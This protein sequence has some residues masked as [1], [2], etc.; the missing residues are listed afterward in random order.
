MV[1]VRTSFPISRSTSHHEQ[2]SPIHSDISESSSLLRDGDDNGK[3]NKRIMETPGVTKDESTISIAYPTD[4]NSEGSESAS[5]YITVIST[6]EEFEQIK[7]YLSS[8]HTEQNSVSDS[9]DHVQHNAS[10][11]IDGKAFNQTHVN[12]MHHLRKI[13]SDGSLKEIAIPSSSNIHG[14]NNE[15]TENKPGRGGKR[16]KVTLI[17]PNDSEGEPN[18]EI[19]PGGRKSP[20]LTTGSIPVLPFV[21]YG[22]NDDFPAT[23]N[24]SN[25]DFPATSNGSNDDFPATSNGSNVDF[26]A[27]SNG[28]IDDFP[29]TSN[30][31]NDDFPATSYESNDGLP[32]KSSGSN[33]GVVVSSS[34]HTTRSGEGVI[35]KRSSLKT[36]RGSKYTHVPLTRDTENAYRPSNT[37]VMT[38]STSLILPKSSMEMKSATICQNL[39]HDDAG[40]EAD[41]EI[42]FSSNE[43]YDSHRIT[44]PC[45]V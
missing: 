22:S 31:S 40:Q 10:N 9:R 45:Q 11:L 12:S 38:K 2:L 43:S 7:S 15:I 33:N 37:S 39:I 3:E 18:E 14:Q 42:G 5:P 32:F 28:S 20:V 19:K 35:E 41:D 13:L 8:I 23:S 17:L 1:G 27:T 25:D 16:K 36:T 24:G 44:Y 29:A 30:G 21:P 26:P 6:P 34:L 4:T